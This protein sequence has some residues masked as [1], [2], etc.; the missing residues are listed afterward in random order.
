MCQFAFDNENL[1]CKLTSIVSVLKRTVHKQ[2]ILQGI[3][4]SNKS[5]GKSKQCLDAFFVSILKSGTSTVRVFVQQAH[6]A[7]GLV[8]TGAGVLLGLKVGLEVSPQVG[9]VGEAAGAVVAG[10]RLLACVNSNVTL[11]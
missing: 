9:L 7:E 10:E 3:L 8:A 6:P 4:G 5:T 1:F 11:K 2:H